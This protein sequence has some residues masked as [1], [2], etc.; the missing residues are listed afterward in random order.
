MP[1]P[2]TDYLIIGA[3]ATGLAFA[4]TLLAETDAHITLVDRHGKPGTAGDAEAGE[5][6]AGL[7]GEAAGEGW[8]DADAEG[9]DAAIAAG[10][11]AGHPSREDGAGVC[12]C[13]RP[14]QRIGPK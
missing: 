11:H 13:V 7:A 5:A 6:G 8:G 9:G 10:V 3:G 4:D 1:H 14:L 2:D 12:A